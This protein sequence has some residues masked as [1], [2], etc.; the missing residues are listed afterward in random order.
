MFA[1]EPGNRGLYKIIAA[2]F[3]ARKQKRTASDLLGELR[4]LGVPSAG[5]PPTVSVSSSADEDAFRIEE[6]RFDGEN[7]WIPA[8]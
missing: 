1:G 5:S 3:Q 4:R 2:E 8:P 6:I 7:L